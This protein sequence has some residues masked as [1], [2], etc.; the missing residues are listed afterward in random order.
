MVM[1][2]DYRA[3]AAQHKFNLFLPR[4]SHHNPTSRKNARGLDRRKNKGER[5]RPGVLTRFRVRVMVR[6]YVSVRM[7]ADMGTFMAAFPLLI[8]FLS[9]PL[10]LSLKRGGENR[11][12]EI[13]N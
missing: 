6:E 10:S 12:S 11:E 1:L 2:P 5:P 4:Y 3:S 8:L 7:E 13:G 9:L